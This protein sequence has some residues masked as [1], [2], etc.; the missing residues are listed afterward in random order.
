MVSISIVINVVICNF[1][2]R[3]SATHEMVPPIKNFFI[4]KLAPML[5]MRRPG[6]LPDFAKVN[7]QGAKHFQTTPENLKIPNY[8][9]PTI[10]SVNYRENHRE[11]LQNNLL[12]RMKSVKFSR[13]FE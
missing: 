9:L 13:L 3:S 1:H 8:L 11:I 2:F 10:D 4:K 6:Q 12:Y 7:D 5:G